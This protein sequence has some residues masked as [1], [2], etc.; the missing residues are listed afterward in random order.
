MKHY[1]EQLSEKD[2]KTLA[3]ATVY[4]ETAISQMVQM[5]ASLGCQF[6]NDQ[7]GQIPEKGEKSIVK[8]SEWAANYTLVC[9]KSLLG[10][11]ITIDL[12]HFKKLKSEQQ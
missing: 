12:S 6:S 2:K 10:T 3:D 9:Q 4:F 8:H 7:I 5:D 11:S 1:I